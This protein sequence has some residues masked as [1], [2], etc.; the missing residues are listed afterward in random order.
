[1]LRFVALCIAMLIISIGFSQKNN[2]YV[3][4]EN[5]A[6]REQFVNFIHIDGRFEFKP[7]SGIILGEIKHVIAPIRASVDS[8]Y[9]DAPNILFESVDFTRPFIYKLRDDKLWIILEK[10]Y[11]SGGSELTL[12]YKATPAKGMYFIGWNDPNNLIPKQIW[13]QGQGI[14]NR[15]WLPCFDDLADKVTTN[16]EIVFDEGYQVISNGKLKSSKTKDGKTTWRY[17][18]EKP[19]APYLIMMAIG[20]YEKEVRKSKNGVEVELYYYPEH[21]D[22]VAQTYRYST[23]MIDYMEDYLNYPY[24]W[25]NYKQVPVADYLYGA[26]ENTTATIFGD[27]FMVDEKAALDREYLDVNAHELAHQW[28]GDLVTARSGPH[29][30]LHESFATFFQ[31]RYTKEVKG[32]DYYRWWMRENAE[33]AI[34]QSTK[35]RMGVGH[36]MAGSN[37]HYLKG[38]FIL[39]MMSYVIGEENF[40]K[41]FNHYLKSFE[42][43]NAE[44][45]D[46]LFAFH[47][48]TGHDLYWFFEEWIKKVAH[49][50]FEVSFIE[51]NDEN[52]K[53]GRFTVRQIHEKDEFVGNFKMSIWFEV[54]Y[55][56]FSKDSQLVWVSED[57]QHIEFKI[58]DNKA[59]NYV[60]FDPNSRILKEVEFQKTKEMLLAQA[61]NARHMIDRYDAVA[62]LAKLLLDDDILKVYEQLVHEDEFQAIK[63]EIAKHLLQ[64]DPQKHASLLR[65]L[66]ADPDP[67]VAKMILANTSFIPDALL[68][69]YE[70]LL[71]APSYEVVEMALQTLYRCKRQNI[72]VY[73]NQ[74]KDMV[75]LKAKNI[76]IAW[77]TIAYL[78]TEAIEFAYELV[79]YTSNS[80]D[81]LT[82]VKAAESLQ[83][84]D[85]L[86]PELALNLMDAVTNPNGRL[87][88]PCGKVLKYFYQQLPNQ[89]L[90]VRAYF[91]KE[92]TAEQKKTIEKFL[93]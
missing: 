11:T 53:K 24:P 30:W 61:V 59:V 44:T 93:R 58:P 43:K 73:L 86:N 76:R 60:L 5:A 83:K 81:F 38:A 14:D 10:P 85:F 32:E 3:F 56:D 23:E 7:D 35:D 22:R 72:G 89:D 18:M 54:H 62:S 13:T 70:A 80:Y 9:V 71:Q 39:D 50:K 17:I 82:R 74:T 55:K 20:S 77:L 68:N 88:R 34:H 31:M 48:A 12:N 36:S 2:T 49:P 42:F 63:A 78:E 67:K 33:K 41:G 28:F 46:L 75:G 57:L 92:W 37:R 47:E 79:K 15:H 66:L 90:I 65:R 27:F 69:D 84:L 19:H 52:A 26:M 8:F 4:D 91:E 40:K 51:L 1:M 64:S 29:H 87:K 16:F 21:K 25:V 45:N 6:P